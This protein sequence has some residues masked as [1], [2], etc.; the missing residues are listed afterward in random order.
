MAT[1]KSKSANIKDVAALANVSVATVSRYL[2]GNL[3][4]MSASTADIIKD[5]IEKLNYVPNSTARQ[6]K[7]KTS[8]MIAVVVSNIDD[9]FSTELFKGIS[10]ML[11]SKGYIGVL[12]DSDSDPDRE[13]AVLKSI[14][15]QMFDGVIIQ[16][17][18]NPSDIQKALVRTI[19]IIIVD[20]EL[21]GSPWPQ[22]VTDNYEI[23]QRATKYF[24]GQGF[25]RVIV[26]TSDVKNART[27]MERYRGIESAT[28]S[29]EL[30]NVPEKSL[31]HAAINKQLEEA[32]RDHSTKTLLFCLKERW[33][34]EFVPNLIFRGFIDNEHVTTT[35]FADTD[36]THMLEPK[37]KLISQNPFLMGADSAEMI[38]N[39]ISGDDVLVDNRMVVP[40]K[41]E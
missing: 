1:K 7:T 35:G 12:F 29:V 13:K 31:N 17:I 32:L 4:R 3:N 24:M 21:D 6:M 22:V 10:S 27:R 8:K 28:D 15:S 26:L 9:F 18:N 34:L 36:I 23:S 41:F 39:V 38:I 11:E 20:R 16:P 14:G 40:A 30:I 19:P 33:M 25:K 5:A 2:N 37:F